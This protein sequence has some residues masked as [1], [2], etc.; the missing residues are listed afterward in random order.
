MQLPLETPLA[1]DWDDESTFEIRRGEVEGTMEGVETSVRM[2]E[3]DCPSSEEE[4]SLSDKL[5]VALGTP[6]EADDC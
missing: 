6:F 3:E 2:S 1:L 5:P 4:C